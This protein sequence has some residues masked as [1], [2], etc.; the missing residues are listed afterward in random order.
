[1]LK[2]TIK[3][4]SLAFVIKSDHYRYLQIFKHQT[5]SIIYQYTIVLIIDHT[6]RE[7]HYC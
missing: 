2:T 3:D 6:I 1:M 7:I 5:N 4:Q